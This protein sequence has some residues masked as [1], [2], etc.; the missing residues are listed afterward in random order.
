MTPTVTGLGDIVEPN[1]VLIGQR[2]SVELDSG[3]LTAKNWHW[4]IT[5]DPFDRY[6]VDNVKQTGNPVE[7]SPTALDQPSVNFVYRSI[8]TPGSIP[9]LG[10]VSYTQA[11][12]R[13]IAASA[14]LV[15]RELD[16]GG[17]VI[18]DVLSKHF[19]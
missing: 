13:L 19:F 15:Q 14:F 10:P 4:T 5:G 2:V 11:K 16:N 1:N 17:T 6:A 3:S 8:G 12:S 9:P 18:G 7:L